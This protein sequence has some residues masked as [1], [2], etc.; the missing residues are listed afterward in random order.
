M[1]PLALRPAKARGTEHRDLINPVGGVKRRVE[2][3]E[4][5]DPS[6]LASLIGRQIFK[7]DQ[8][9]AR[10]ISAR[11]KRQ[12]AAAGLSPGQHGLFIGPAVASAPRFDRWR[13]VPHQN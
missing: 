9:T 7:P 8:L 4:S 11:Q 5:D 2:P 13:S 3:Q 10:A 6:N 12:N 1:D